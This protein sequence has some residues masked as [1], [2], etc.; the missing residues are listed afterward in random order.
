MIFKILM[1][2]KMTEN[3]FAEAW[4][5]KLA[6]QKKQFNLRVPA[7]IPVRPFTILKKKF[8]PSL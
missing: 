5:F 7:K 8:P 6:S 4:N 3:I 2:L 1:T